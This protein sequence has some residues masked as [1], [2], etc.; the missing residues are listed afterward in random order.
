MQQ[1]LTMAFL[2][3]L[4][5]ALAPGSSGAAEAGPSPAPAARPNIL[6][7]VADDLGYADVGFNG[8]RRIATPNL[9]RLA[10]TGVRLTDFR[11][12]PMC[13]PTLL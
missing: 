4:A 6:I 3:A 5:I 7:I 11:S 8:G 1:I 12:A 9:D 10:A 13:S 2:G